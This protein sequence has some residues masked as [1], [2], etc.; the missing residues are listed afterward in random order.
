MGNSWRDFKGVWIPRE[1]WLDDRLNALDKVILV[2]ID[3]LDSLERGC[4]ASNKH[5]AEFC[6]CS[7][8]KVS[9]TITKL[10]RLGYLSVISFDG[11]QR[12]IKSN[13]AV[14]L[15]IYEAD[16]QNLTGRL[17]N[18]NRQTRKIYEAD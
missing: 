7:E 2:E 10:S 13:I 4:W 1:I 5:I 15:K 6:Q 8:S 9:Q 17:L 12:E 11:R 16:S 14:G 3:S 18:F